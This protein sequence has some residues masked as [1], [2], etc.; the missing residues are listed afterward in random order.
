M[1]LR[2]C[3]SKAHREGQYYWQ[4]VESH[5][6]QRGPRQRVVAYLGDVEESLRQ[7]VQEAA[8][9]QPSPRQEPLFSESSPAPQWVEVDASRIR[10]ERCREFGG[11]W[12]ALQV[13]EQL[14]LPE[15]WR[16]VL[17]QDR[18]EVEWWAMALVLVIARWCHPSSE[19]HIAEHFYAD[20]S[21]SDLLGIPPGK[22]DDHRLYRALDKLL[23]HKPALEQ[24]L[25]A[26][27]GELFQLDYEL[28]LYDV[29]ST[30]FEGMAEGNPQAQRGYSRDQRPDCKQV[31]IA[32][33]V[34]KSGMPLAYEV[35]DGNR[36]DVTTVEEI[37]EGVEARF[38]QADRIWVMDRGMTSEDN[39]E[40]LQEGQRR[41]IL[42]APR[43][44]LKAFEKQLL[45]GSWQQ[46]REGLEVQ[47]CASPNGPETFILCRSAARRLKDQAI[48]HK[49]IQRL[50]AKLEKLQT[51]CQTRKYQVSR[52]ERRVGRI[53][54]QC[55]RAAAGF[56]VEVTTS[57]KGGAR[58]TWSQE[59]AWQD[60][61]ALTE[62]CYLLRSNIRDWTA[63]D[64]W[65]AY[66]QLTEA[67]NAFKIHKQDLSLRPIWHQ[68]KERVQ[69]H[70]LV[71][72]LAF[73]GWQ[74]LGQFCRLAGLGDEPRK[75]F[76][77]LAT[78]RSV[79][80]VLPTKQG[81]EIRRRLVTQPT[82][83][84]QILLQRLRLN[85]PETLSIHQL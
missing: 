5:R 12:L 71:C 78:L 23:P 36:T 74:A 6:T 14:Q 3:R 51:V 19:L 9:G 33:V 45:E 41:Y 18:A 34:T 56:T 38:G 80:V 46:V 39:L 17:P 50:T 1:Y 16:T 69:A 49:A 11:P 43:C 28:L 83:A 61:A 2:R 22:I 42:G 32:L 79:D 63:Q 48:H 81:P 68:K 72:F 67:E 40:F 24:H 57:D 15:L 76:N 47:L 20:S 29:T 26:R 30:Y 13:L 62:G 53:L 75:V 58:V 35:F 73:V 37:V 54:E 31:C 44:Q 52:I 85:L 10:V 60:W 27:L 8:A 66:I 25:K 64:L 70:I 84:Q 59:P 77:E 65:Q 21:L 82:P 4:L 55:S 7:G